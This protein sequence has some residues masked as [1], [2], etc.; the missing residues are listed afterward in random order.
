MDDQFCAQCGTRLK[1]E[2]RFCTNCG[3]SVAP[4]PTVKSSRPH[5]AARRR[6]PWRLLILSVGGALGA[7]GAVLYQTTPPAVVDVPDEHDASGLPYPDVPR[8]SVEETRKLFD[9]NSAV[10]IDVR[11]ALDYAEVHIPG[12]LSIPLEEL[13]SRY[14]EL[15][16]DAEII[17]YCT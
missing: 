6:R 11:D 3:A 17:T 14:Q 16:P 10:I 9:N 2:A 1:T 8:I 12:A 13:Q 7:V 4:K 15:P 5:P